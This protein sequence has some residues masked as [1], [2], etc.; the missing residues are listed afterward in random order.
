MKGCGCKSF[1]TAALHPI[2]AKELGMLCLEG[3]STE[4][5]SKNVTVTIQPD[6]S[7]HDPLQDREVNLLRVD[8]RVKGKI[9]D[10][11]SSQSLPVTYIKTQVHA[12]AKELVSKLDV[13][14]DVGQFFPTETAIQKIVKHHR[15]QLKLDPLDHVSV[16][17]FI[18]QDSTA[19]PGMV[20]YCKRMHPYGFLCYCALC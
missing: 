1:M 15:D 5:Y 19:N 7:G 3:D 4:P 18:E 8:A 12:Y 17:K 9:K 11:A 13:K 10:L 6:H 2:Y 16:Q 14:H 20:G